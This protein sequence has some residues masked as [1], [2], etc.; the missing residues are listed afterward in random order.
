MPFL[1][2]RGQLDRY[3][4]PARTAYDFDEA[5]FMSLRQVSFSTATA[6][7]PLARFEGP[8]FSDV[9]AHVGAKGSRLA[10]DAIDNYSAMIPRSD[11]ATFGVIVAHSMNGKRLAVRDYGPLWVMYPRD[12]F[13]VELNSAVAQTKFIWQVRRVNVAD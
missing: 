12:K 6:W 1:V 8:L 9:L 2:V 5:E 10:V 3:T 13:P 4:D 11:L 7:T